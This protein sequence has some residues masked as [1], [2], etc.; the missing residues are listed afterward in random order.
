MSLYDRPNLYEM[1]EAVREYITAEVAP[2]AGDRRSRFRALI[3]ANVLAIVERELQHMYEHEKQEAGRWAGFDLAG[4]DAR[5][6]RHELARHI[7]EGH[8]D[9]EPERQRAL[10]YA[11]QAV[12]AKLAVANPKFL[13]DYRF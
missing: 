4:A 10:T 9:E 6:R 11:K 2:A 5:A 12:S 13:K 3:A 8:F 1:I 7:R